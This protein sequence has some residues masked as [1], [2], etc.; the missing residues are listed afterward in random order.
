MRRKKVNQCLKN[1]LKFLPLMGV[2]PQT[3]STTRSFQLKWKNDQNAVNNKNGDNNKIPLICSKHAVAGLG[4]LTDHGFKDH[5]WDTQQQGGQVD[6][7]HMNQQSMER[8]YNNPHHFGHP[9]VHNVGRGPLLY[10]FRNYLVSNLLG[11]SNN[12]T[13]LSAVSSPT[14]K[15]VFSIHSSSD[16]DRDLDFVSQINVVRQAFPNTPV[17]VVQF[18]NLTLTEQVTLVSQ[19]TNLL[20]TACGG[21]AVTSTFLR[22]GSSIIM[23]YKETGGFNFHNFNLTGSPARL[24]WDLLNNAGYLRVHW[25]PI[26]PMNTER[27]LELLVNLVRHEIDMSGISLDP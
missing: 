20:V 19:E 23:Y 17:E 7:T 1:L 14:Y 26:G 18:S 16:Y 24:D 5:G 12:P 8:K 25:L 22:R 10:N 13:E 3:F 15:I 11:T 27:G 9:V 4:M 21:G 2:N 6:R